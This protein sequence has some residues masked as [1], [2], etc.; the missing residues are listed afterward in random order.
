MRALA[1]NRWFLAFLAMLPICWLTACYFLGAPQNTRPTGF[2]QYDQ[3]YYMA[4]ARQH[5]DDGFHLFYGLP[6]SSD[7][8]TPRVYFHPQTLL[9]GALAQSTGIEPGW[10]YVAFGLIATFI[11][12]RIA[13]GL[14]EYVVGLRSGAQFLV[15]PLFL[16]GGGLALLCGFLFN[17]TVGGALQTFD[18]GSWG[19][20]LGRG[21]IYGVEGYYHALFFAAILVLLRRRYAIALLLVAVTCASHPFTG[22]ELA[23]I[24][25]GWVILEAVVDNKAA[26]PLW[27]RA[28][29]LLLLLLHLS[30]W[31]ILLPRLSP[32]HAALTPLWQLPWVLHWYN[33]IPEYAIVGLAALWQLGSKQRLASALRDRTV[34]LMLAWFVGA[35]LLAN[36]DL[37]ISPRQ[38]IHFTHGYLW[39][40]LFL[41]GAPVIVKLAEQLLSAPWRIGLS[42][43]IVLSGL[44]FL[45]NAGWFG[46][47]G[48]DLLRSGNSVS[49]FPNPIYIGRS[50]RDVLE[51]LN[52]KAFAGGLVVSNARALSYQV[53]VY[54]P[55]R[56]WYSQMWNTPHPL[57]RLA[58]LDAL[59]QDGR[60]FSDWCCRKMIAIVDRRNDGEAT[61]KLLALGYELVYQNIDFEVLLRPPRS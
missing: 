32:E 5:F 7:Y 34:R 33:E 26:P 35:F 54:T 57:E 25:A 28:G 49:F 56:A 27:F 37:L 8:D 23:S 55:L 30:Y 24:L 20:N 53:T 3:A 46:G 12:F 48:L 58:E 13:I 60:D 16:W 29:I 9:L 40:P 6:A 1:A 61:A 45:D 4:E 43:S 22:V 39:V 17:V 21:V 36:H 41:I 47:A 14:Y 19:A 15:L 18:T 59:F 44:V 52:D 50:A 11:F 42:A 51:R 31:L 10:V 2:I 38:P